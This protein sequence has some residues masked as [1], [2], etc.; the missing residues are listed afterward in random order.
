MTKTTLIFPENLNKEFELVDCHYCQ[1]TF[2]VKNTIM[3]INHNRA[4]EECARIVKRYMRAQK[5][6]AKG[7]APFCS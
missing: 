1:R 2:M 7:Y 4:C 3:D 5:R 6:K